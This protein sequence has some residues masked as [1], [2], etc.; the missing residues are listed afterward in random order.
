MSEVMDRLAEKNQNIAQQ[1][2]EWQI[3]RTRNNDDAYD[4][5]AFRNHQSWMGN[6][7][8]GVEEPDEF[9]QY[10]WTQYRTDK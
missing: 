5:Q 2:N 9:R 4:W 6:E 10:D 3:S 1:L 8:P 7:D